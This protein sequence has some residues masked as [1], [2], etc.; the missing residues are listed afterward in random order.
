MRLWRDPGPDEVGLLLVLAAAEVVFLGLAV[1]MLL[2]ATL[3]G[4]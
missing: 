1:V 3:G 2:K 4:T